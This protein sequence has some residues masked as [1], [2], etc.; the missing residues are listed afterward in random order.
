[1]NAITVVVADDQELVRAGFTV[2]INSDPGLSVVG[3]AGTGTQAVEV[4]ERTRPDVVLMDIQMPEMDGIE[5]TRR[6]LARPKPVGRVLILTTF[7]ID[8]YVFAAL[9]AG[10]SGF[11]LKNTPPANLLDAIRVIAAGEALLAPSIT[12]RLIDKFTSRPANAL[13][14]TW[15]LEQ[16]TP[17]ERQV[18]YLVGRGHSN[19]EIAGTLN[20]SHGTVKT[21]VSHLLAKLDARDRIQLVIT[22]YES[23]LMTE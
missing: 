17:R 22:A 5:A 15:K 19:K 10:A 13:W 2:L 16:I 4:V 8:K 21:H 6:L 11:L 3:E 18:L 23:G 9:D 20:V 14:A 12:R 1:M 7:N